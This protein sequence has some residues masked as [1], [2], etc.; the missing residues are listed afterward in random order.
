MIFASLMY[1]QRFLARAEQ[2][3]SVADLK[4]GQIQTRKYIWCRCSYTLNS[5]LG[6]SDAVLKDRRQALV[7]HGYSPFPA[8]L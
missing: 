8:A 7:F 1:Q 6:Q 2:Q 5:S 4:A 3:T